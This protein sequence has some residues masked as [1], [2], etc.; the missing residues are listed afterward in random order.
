MLA[1]FWTSPLE[2]GP[3]R[4]GPILREHQMGGKGPRPRSVENVPG[5]S[6][7]CVP[8]E[9]LTGR[10]S[11]PLA[12]APRQ[13]LLGRERALQENACEK[14]AVV[15]SSEAD[16]QLKAF[17]NLRAYSCC[18]RSVCGVLLDTSRQ[19]LAAIARMHPP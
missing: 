11:R 8:N 19:R 10:E 15:T 6:W 13:L 1:S 2:P 3:V 16:E 9:S 5:Q 4:S 7:C 18:E 12:S 17:T 14:P